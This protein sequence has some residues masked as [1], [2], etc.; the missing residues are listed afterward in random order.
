VREDRQ[1]RKG[2]TRAEA[3]DYLMSQSG[4]QYDPRVV[5]TF[6]TH[7]PEFEAEIAAHRNAS[8]PTYGIEPVEQLSEAARQVAPAAGL[9]EA[10]AN[11]PHAQLTQFEFTDAER[12]HLSTAARRLSEARDTDEVLAAF[13]ESLKTLVPYDSCALT[14]APPHAD[15]CLIAYADG[16]H[17]DL[18]NN[19]LIIPGEG[20]TGWVLANRQPFYNAD[21]KLDLPPALAARDDS[22]R[23]LAACPILHDLELHGVV[24]LYS[25]TLRTYETT[26]QKLIEALASL[27]A[28][29]LSTDTRAASTSLKILPPAFDGSTQR[30]PAFS[31]L[32]N[33]TGVALESE[34]A[35]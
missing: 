9:A 19:V 17:A 30:A 29:A 3:I 27:L 15:E 35:H 21:P 14:L 18:L 34:L 26:H 16:R 24:T 7:L 13:F 23:T 11:T 5:G 8:A 12:E 4:T 33:L 28:T 25:A 1:Y 22:Y 2:M 20:V 31:M 6:I 32:P 10:T